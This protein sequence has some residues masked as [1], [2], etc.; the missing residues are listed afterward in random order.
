[1]SKFSTNS[2]VLSFRQFDRLDP[3]RYVTND[4][5]WPVQIVECYANKVSDDVLD[6]LAEGT[7][8]LLN[9]PGVSARR[10]SELLMVGPE[11]IESIARD[12]F[13][14]GF[15]DIERKQVTEAGREY[16]ENRDLGEFQEEKVFGC[17]FVSRIDGEVFPYF[18][19]G[20]LPWPRSYDDIN[21]LLFDRDSQPGV[22]D[23]DRN[24]AVDRINKAFHRYGRITK[25]SR[26]QERSGENSSEIEF[27]DE[28]LTEESFDEP[29]TLAEKEEIRDL[30][31]ARVKIL[32]TPPRDAYVRVR[33]VVEK[34]APEKFKVESPFTENITSW[35]SDCFHRMR[36]NHELIGTGNNGEQE[37]GTFCESI[38]SQFYQKFPEML[39]GN[40][41]QFVKNRYPMMLSCSIK[42]ICFEKYREIFNYVNLYEKR[43]INASTVVTESVKALEMILNNYI[44]RV[45]KAYIIQ[46]YMNTIQ[47]KNEIVD[48]FKNLGITNC[49][50]LRSESGKTDS[51]GRIGRQ[52]I[53]SHFYGSR[54][55]HSVVEKYYFLVAEAY[56]EEKSHFRKLLLNEG[57]DIIE[58]LDFASNVRNKFGA[59]NDGD[60]PSEISEQEYEKFQQ[61]FEKVTQLL[62]KYID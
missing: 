19:E 35:Y 48:M 55:G 43:E 12:L 53:M 15:Y 30:K 50:G 44:K 37:L 34:G 45:H 41:E 13:A 28:E 22:L 21:F 9:V 58:K 18:Y 16:L 49:S 40:F 6:A 38:T 4:L 51:Y 1:M 11:V 61:D 32:K 42:P 46:K 39:K 27:F 7:L 29:E 56:F 10:V 62:L 60:R 31:N 17:M 24:D 5:A 47:Y 3:D 14:K 59:H 20:K 8:E 54:S 2:G 52:S 57:P 33:L 36:E 25:S 23:G 26:D